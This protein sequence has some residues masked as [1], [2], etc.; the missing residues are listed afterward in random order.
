MNNPHSEGLEGDFF[1]TEKAK[2]FVELQQ[3]EGTPRPPSLLLRQPVIDIPLVLRC[4]SHPPAC[5]IR[6]KN[7]KKN[8]KTLAPQEMTSQRDRANKV[9]DVISLEIKGSLQILECS[10]FLLLF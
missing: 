4:L 9:Y 6:R 2:L 1:T 10:E 3:L 8:E 7:G 5:K